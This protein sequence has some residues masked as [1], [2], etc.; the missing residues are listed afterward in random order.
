MRE[1]T[2]A[3]EPVLIGET[4]IL[5]CSLHVLLTLVSNTGKPF[6]KDMLFY[7]EDQKKSARYKDIY[8]AEKP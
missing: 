7:L 1:G 6:C 2:Q 5:F 8:W 3:K 4:D